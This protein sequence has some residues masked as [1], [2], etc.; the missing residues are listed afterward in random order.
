M[1]SE[2][3]AMALSRSER[4]RAN[5]HRSAVFWLTG[6]S[7]AGKTTVAS[8][9]EQLL[10]TMGYQVC[11]LDGDHLR[12]GLNAD[13][14]FDDADRHE[15]MRRAGHMAE[16]FANTGM[17]VLVAL[18]SPFDR[19]R[20]YARQAVSADFYEVYVATTLDLCEARDPK[21]LYRKARAGEIHGFTGISSPYEVP[22]APDTSIDTRGRTPS[23]SIDEFVQYVRSKVELGRLPRYISA[24]NARGVGRRDAI[25]Q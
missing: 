10:Y 4:E 19:G 20:Q 23:Q 15:S 5:G 21:G 25:E 3:G 2:F 16:A 11:V 12:K 24:N 6:L 8:G 17:I 1:A 22:V 13:L 14:G 9:A 18:I 7:G